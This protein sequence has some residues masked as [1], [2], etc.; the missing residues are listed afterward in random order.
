MKACELGG[1]VSQR[2]NDNVLDTA[3][4]EFVERSVQKYRGPRLE[5]FEVGWLGKGPSAECDHDIAIESVALE[6]IC[7]FAE[8]AGFGE[9]KAD[10]TSV[11]KNLGNR[12][13]LARLNSGIQIHKIPIQAAS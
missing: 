3:P 2:A 9:A 5:Q 11:P 7:Q 6:R 13:L 1:I 10:F 8:R 4:P 12:L